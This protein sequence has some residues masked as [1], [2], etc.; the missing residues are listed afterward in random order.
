MIFKKYFKPVNK[1]Q[2]Q[3]VIIELK[4]QNSLMSSE[5]SQKI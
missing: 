2:R 4:V 5:N 1:E 3:Q